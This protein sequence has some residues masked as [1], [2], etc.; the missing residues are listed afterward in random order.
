MQTTENTEPAEENGGPPARELGPLRTGILIAATVPMLVVGGLGAW[1]TFT[2]IKTEFP[3]N[4]TALGVVVAG[5]GG[6][7]ILALVMVLVTLLGQSSPRM[8][9]LGLW[10]LPMVASATGT[11]VAD[12]AEE[13][14]VYA[15]TPLAMIAASEGLGLIA[16]RVVVF[17]TGV[18]AEARR[19]N[20]STM[21]RLAVLRALANGHP[22]GWYRKM[23]ELASWRLVRKVGVGDDDLGAGLVSVQRDRLGEG[24]DTALATML[25]LPVTA[26]V[27]ELAASVTPA[28]EPGARNDGS[29][30]PAGALA[31]TEPGG[32]HSVDTVAGG[33]VTQVSG[34]APA[35]P[36]H[37]AGT[38]TGTDGAAVTPS[39]TESVTGSATNPVSGTVPVTD[40]VTDSTGAAGSVTPPAAPKTTVT[41]EEVA[42]VAGVPVPETGER[43]TDEQLLV[44][45]R[46]LRYRKDPPTSYRQAVADFREAGFVGGEERIRRTWGELMSREESDTGQAAK[47]TDEADPR[48]SD[49]DAK[50]DEE[51]EEEAGPKS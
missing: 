47:E 36:S 28:L 48:H 8:V 23:S 49:E 31:V 17:C 29:V 12:N 25:G 33:V 7:L 26:A 5:E 32:S 6:T 46:H 9:R 44:V 43:L 39:V 3:R 45:L 15:V 14:M 30:A 10:L 1:G 35:G 42:A 18:D 11:V 37:P 51:D 40:T 34:P 4:A 22:W 24:A 20:A 13:R 38:V 41:L 50:A 27:P 16:R 21:Q 2:N 19:R